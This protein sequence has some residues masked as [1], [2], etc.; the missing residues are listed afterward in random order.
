METE[1]SFVD[2]FKDY[3]KKNKFLSIAVL[4]LIIMIIVLVIVYVNMTPKIASGINNQPAATTTPTTQTTATANVDVLPQT[5]R[6]NETV[7]TSTVTDSAKNP[8]AGPVTLKGTVLNN[9]GGNLAIVE[10]GG[11]TFIVAKDETIAEIWTVKKITSGEVILVR[12]GVETV[13]KV[14]EETVAQ[15]SGTN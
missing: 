4:I 9:K 5:Q 8:F 6:T 7:S 10:A 2:K 3:I 11:S 15:K 1:K 13:I 12:D 14:T